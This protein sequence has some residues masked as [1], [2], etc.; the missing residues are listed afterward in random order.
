MAT[1]N[2]KSIEINKAY[3]KEIAKNIKQMVIHIDRNKY[4]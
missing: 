4:D 3:F 1:T 2:T